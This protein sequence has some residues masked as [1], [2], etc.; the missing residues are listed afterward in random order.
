MIPQMTVA[1]DLPHG[2][3][4]LSLKPTYAV[5]HCR[6]RQCEKTVG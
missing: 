3:D 1:A 5:G 4:P 2:E 6:T